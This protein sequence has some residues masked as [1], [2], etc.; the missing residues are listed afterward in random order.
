MTPLSGFGTLGLK[1]KS[2]AVIGRSRRRRTRTFVADEERI[3]DIT[4]L[5]A[6][7]SVS[8]F[9][10]LVNL[11]FIWRDRFLG[12]IWASTASRNNVPKD[13]FLPY[14]F[15]IGRQALPGLIML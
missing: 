14:V 12:V 5:E 4:H 9:I 13:E 8:L 1:G 7:P 15:S 11:Q 2:D 3:W 10:R 6:I